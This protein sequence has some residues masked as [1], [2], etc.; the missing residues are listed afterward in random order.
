MKCPLPGITQHCHL[1][2]CFVPLRVLLLLQVGVACGEWCQYSSRVR[3][4][5]LRLAIFCLISELSPLSTS[6][7]R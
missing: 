1:S 3:M 5:C 2:L 6:T 4:E 7:M